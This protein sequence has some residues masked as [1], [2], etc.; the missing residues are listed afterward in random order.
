MVLFGFG[1]RVQR[2]RLETK[3]VVCVLRCLVLQRYDPEFN[4]FD[5]PYAEEVALSFE[6]CYSRE[7]FIVAR[8]CKYQCY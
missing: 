2:Q 8:R 5:E 4:Q 3:H 6:V 1:E 7:T